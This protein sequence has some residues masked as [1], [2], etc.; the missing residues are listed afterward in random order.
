MNS[1]ATLPKFN[2]TSNPIPKPNPL[3]IIVF[4]GSGFERFRGILSNQERVELART[5]DSFIPIEKL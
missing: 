4:N 1:I 5:I 2:P 3:L